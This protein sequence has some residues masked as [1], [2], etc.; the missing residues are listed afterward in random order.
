MKQGY[1][2]EVLLS[3][4]CAHKYLCPF[5]CVP[6]KEYLKLGN[7]LKEKVYLLRGSAGF[8]RSMARALAAC[9]GLRKLPLLAEGKGEKVCAEITWRKRKQRREVPGPLH[10]N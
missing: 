8:T 2:L 6:I 5:F 1:N 4:T 10:W 9:E 7:L 3:R